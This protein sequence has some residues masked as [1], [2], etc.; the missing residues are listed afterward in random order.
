MPSEPR[1]VGDVV[2]ARH[3]ARRHDPTRSSLRHDIEENEVGTVHPAVAFD[4]GDQIARASGP[5]QRVEGRPKTPPNQRTAPGSDLGVCYV[6]ITAG[7]HIER[8][9]YPVSMIA[10]RPGAPAEVR[11]RIGRDD[12]SAR[13]EPDRSLQRRLVANPTR[14]LD[15]DIGGLDDRSERRFIRSVTECVVEV[16]QMNPF[17][18]FPMP[19]TCDVSRGSVGAGDRSTGDVESGEQRK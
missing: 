13:P 11:E 2:R 18:T 14:Q 16:D 8:D 9:D 19:P 1:E 6:R 7:V 15:L 10:Y 12:D 17:G 4:I 3:T 5:I